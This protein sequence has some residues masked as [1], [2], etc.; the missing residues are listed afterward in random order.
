MMDV[1]S[2][3]RTTYNLLTKPYLYVARCLPLQNKVVFC[4]YFGNGMADDPKYIALELLKRKS[5]IKLVWMLRDM[6]T[7]LPE[8]ITPVKYASIKAMWH[9]YTAKVWVYNF[10]NAFKVEHK[11]KGQYYI[12]CW[13]GSYATK[14]FEQDAEPLLPESYVKASKA[15]S[16]MIDLMYSNN[17]FKVNLFK[18]KCWYN[19]PVIKSDSPQLSILINTPRELKEK[20]Y[21][22]FGLK[23]DDKI[24]LYS[25]TFR[26]SSDVKIYFW[27]YEKI[28][29]ALE[30]RFGGHFVFLLRLHPNMAHLWN[31]L[32]YSSRVIQASTYPDIDELMAVSEVMISDFSGVIFDMGIKRSPVFLYAEDCKEYIEKERSQYNTLDELPFSM[33]TNVEDLVAKIRSFDAEKYK[34]GLDD[35]YESIGL[36]ENGN[37]AVN[38]ANII[39]AQIMK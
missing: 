22:T 31:G 27:E 1:R 35:F 12:Q 3:F 30:E 23:P 32:N 33:S 14:T 11:R 21:D 17:D 18:T 29:P 24:V 4:N 9:L 13:H 19:G 20:V 5:P 10:K 7:P 34:R 8:G 37:G 28:I 26:Q 25:P 38:I 36:E 6:S 2:V 39:E 16:K 15:D